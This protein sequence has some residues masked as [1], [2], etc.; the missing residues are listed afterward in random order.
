MIPKGEHLAFFFAFL[1]PNSRLGL[2]GLLPCSHAWASSAHSLLLTLQDAAALP[3]S[4]QLL[5]SQSPGGLQL[6]AE[7]TSLPVPVPDR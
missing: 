5:A 7:S 3:F 1:K 2:S 6:D 4:D